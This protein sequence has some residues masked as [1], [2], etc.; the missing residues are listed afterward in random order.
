MSIDPAEI[1]LTPK[2]RFA[3]AHY[4]NLEGKQWEEILEDRFPLL[5]DPT[6]EELSKSLAL[7]D[8]GM[9]DAQ[10]G[11]GTDAKAA[12]AQIADRFGKKFQQ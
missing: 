11:R 5:N 3:I 1:Q 6:S 9:A 7:C 12:I 4:A 2:L 10:S 8:Q